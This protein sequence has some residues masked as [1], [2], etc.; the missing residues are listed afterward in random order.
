MAQYIAGCGEKHGLVLSPK[1]LQ[2][3]AKSVEAMREGVSASRVT[4]PVGSC[5]IV[6]SNLWLRYQHVKAN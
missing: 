5:G 2:L 6:Q 3:V 4:M 1:P